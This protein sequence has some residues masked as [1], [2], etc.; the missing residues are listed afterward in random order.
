[1][2]ETSAKMFSKLSRSPIDVTNSVDFLVY[3]IK[4]VDIIL[5]SL[6]LN[7]NDGLPE[8]FFFNQNDLMTNDF[9]LA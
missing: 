2:L 7:N 9:L 5:P 3:K 6:I 1:M 8:Y 4:Q